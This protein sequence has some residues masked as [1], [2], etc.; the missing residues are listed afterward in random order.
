MTFRSI[1]LIALSSVLFALSSA[2]RS[3]CTPPP[4]DPDQ[5]FKLLLQKIAAEPPDPC[6]PPN[7]PD[8]KAS[9][10]E[11]HLFERAASF[12]VQELNADPGGARP[13]HHR[14]T[15][16]LKKLERLSAEIDSAWP[17]ENRFHFQVLDLTPALVVKMTIRT[18]DSFFVFG[19]PEESPGKPNRLWQE[20]GS[21]GDFAGEGWFGNQLD[22]YPLHRGP[23]GNARFL[24]VFN[25]SGCA[26]NAIGIAYEAREWDPKS[27]SGY[28][29]AIIKQEGSLGLSTTPG[30]HAPTPKDPFAP[31][32]ELKTEGPLLTLPY[33]WFS[34]ID[35]WDNPSMC[36]VDTYDLSGDNVRF[37]SRA[38]NRP[39]LVPIAKA[40]EYAQ[41]RDF[42]AVLAYCASGGVARRL[43]RDI[44]PDAHADDL[45][46]TRTAN[47]MERIE[48]VGLSTTYR[49]DVEKRAGRWLVVAFSEE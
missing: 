9:E 37:R 29:G 26:G 42:P 10:I 14:A 15:G 2:S 41:Q 6:D 11:F 27:G 45:R 33:C 24:V 1:P 8:D 20:V 48:L 5:D 22:L 43:V 3:Y 31:I 46:V 17:E 39:D 12:V 28:S 19:I 23:S 38:Y 4:T 35:T 21:D 25:N 16:A 44:P 36:A 18:H 13:P 40:I 49:F 34:A 47:G 30:V 32:G 7:G